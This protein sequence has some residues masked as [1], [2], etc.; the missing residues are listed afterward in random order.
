VKSGSGRKLDEAS[1]TEVGIDM[2]SV[3]SHVAGSAFIYAGL[4]HMLAAAFR[5]RR[6]G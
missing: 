1:R 2:H 5:G 6:T 3:Q 4:S